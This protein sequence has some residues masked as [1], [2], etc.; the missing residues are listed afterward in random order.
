M[1]MKNFLSLKNTCLLCI[2]SV[3]VTVGTMFNDYFYLEF[4]GK[5]P[6]V[7]III[8]ALGFATWKYVASASVK[9][10]MLATVAITLA[11][12]I[13]AV[14]YELF[15]TFTFDMHQSM[16]K[17]I[18]TAIFVVVGVI[19]IRKITDKT[20]KVSM[21]VFLAVGS[22]GLWL[23]L[24]I[25]YDSRTGIYAIMN[26]IALLP[27]IAYL[28]FF[29]M[30]FGETSD[31]RLRTSILLSVVGCVLI[32][33]LLAIIYYQTIHDTYSFFDDGT[34]VSIIL[35]LVS[36]CLM[37]AYFFH[38]FAKS[39][40]TMKSICIPVITGTLCLGVLSAF[41]VGNGGWLGNHIPLGFIISSFG[42]YKL[43]KRL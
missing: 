14:C 20:E 29:G 10:A 37:S 8:V 35:S 7:L 33:V 6:F 22:V 21:V 27:F 15:H 13:P 43:Y 30:S 19:G 28:L 38:L 18:L 41:I 40:Y 11:N 26:C 25:P 36:G 39:K 4:W 17:G 42:I 34:Q 2:L 1:T 24:I 5:L 32:P 16:L 9:W 23:L 3:L 31:K 12:L